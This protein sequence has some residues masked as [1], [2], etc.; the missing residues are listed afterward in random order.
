M[1]LGLYQ[2]LGLILMEY[3]RVYFIIVARNKVFFV[4]FGMFC[5]YG[6]LRMHGMLRLFLPTIAIF[7]I[8]FLVM[9]LMVA[10]EFHSRSRAFINAARTRMTMKITQN[11]GHEI[12]WLRRYL[13]TL[14]ELKVHVGSLYY[15]DKP[16]VLTMFKII[17][18]SIISFLL[19]TNQD[20]SYVC[21]HDGN[22]DNSLKCGSC[23]SAL[24]FSHVN[25][26]NQ[27][28][29]VNLCRKCVYTL[30]FNPWVSP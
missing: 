16:I 4:S 5:T 6:V 17:F 29:K 24:M 3:K 25:H 15:I 10:G 23:I 28:L 21:T 27:T 20:S 30:H 22:I 11:R 14:P 7:S 13:R 8:S 12:K 18:D 26:Y 2:K 9:F 1:V 19:M